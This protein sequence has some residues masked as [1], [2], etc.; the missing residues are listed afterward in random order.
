MIEQLQNI[1]REVFDDD[2]I[3]L[4]MDTSSDDLEDWDSFNHVK[5]ILSCEESFDI[6][7]DVQ[8][9]A[10]LTNIRSLILTIKNKLS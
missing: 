5:L 2:K 7:F 4:S 6:K 10:E 1:F 9:V 3:E 8:E